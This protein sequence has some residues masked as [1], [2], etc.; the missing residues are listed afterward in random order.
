MKDLSF[1]SGAAQNWKET[2]AKK[3]KL[4]SRHLRVKTINLWNKLPMSVVYFSLDSFLALANLLG[5]MQG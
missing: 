2:E 4:E 1:Y 5:L 3:I